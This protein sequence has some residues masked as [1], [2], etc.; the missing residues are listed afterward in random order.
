MDIMFRYQLGRT[1]PAEDKALIIKFLRT[2]TGEPQPRLTAA[3]AKAFDFRD[4]KSAS[5][6]HAEARQ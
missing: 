5:V 6:S 4:G 2:L 1:A 3:D